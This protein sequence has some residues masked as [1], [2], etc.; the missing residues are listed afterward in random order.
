MV[1]NV[2]LVGN[3]GR[4]AT[5][6][7]FDKTSLAEFS[8][9]TTEKWKKGDE[10]Q[11]ETQWHQVKLFGTYAAKQAEK[12]VKGAT[13]CVTG[14]IKYRTYDDKD[15]NKKYITEIIADSVKVIG[16]RDKKE[17][18]GSTYSSAPATDNNMDTTS[19]GT[20]DDLPF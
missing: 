2:T 15:G 8:L 12:F 7:Q 17:D 13:A 11:E 20:G 19:G 6:K 9:A 10:W 18:S 3:I 1:N 16:G 5:T 14:K 4:D